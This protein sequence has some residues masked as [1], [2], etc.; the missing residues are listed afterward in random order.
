MSS[1][2]HK[3]IDYYK[4]L[5]IDETSSS[6]EVRKAYLKMAKKYQMKNDYKNP[7]TRKRVS[8]FAKGD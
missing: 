7:P 1:L 5:G 4:V 6:E 2:N 3:V 8:P